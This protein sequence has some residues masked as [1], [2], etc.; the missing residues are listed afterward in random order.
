[1][2]KIFKMVKRYKLAAQLQLGNTSGLWKI[3]TKKPVYWVRSVMLKK[4]GPI[5]PQIKQLQSLSYGFQVPMNRLILLTKIFWRAMLR[6]W[7]KIL[8]ET[9]GI[10]IE[11]WGHGIHLRSYYEIHVLL[12]KSTSMKQM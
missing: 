7:L 4:K 10:L 2:V 5:C 1:M 6:K 9:L 3:N 11:C 12:L 8:E